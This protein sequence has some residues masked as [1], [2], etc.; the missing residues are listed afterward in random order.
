D[1]TVGVRQIDA[2]PRRR[3]HLAVRRWRDQRSR[4]CIPDDATAT[5]VFPDWIAARGDRLPGRDR[6]LQPGPDERRAR[7]GGPAAAWSAAGRGSALESHAVAG[8]AT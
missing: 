6:K 5:A 2:V 7:N 1:R 4:Q 8:R 3:G